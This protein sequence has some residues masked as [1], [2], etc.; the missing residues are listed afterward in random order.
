[1]SHPVRTVPGMTQIAHLRSP[2]PAGSVTLPVEPPHRVVIEDLVVDDAVVAELLATQPAADRPAV[3]ARALVVGAR[4]LLTMG[5]GVNLD[6]VDGRVRRALDQVAAEALACSREA[7]ESGRRA[8][9][10][11][12]DPAQRSSMIGRALDEFSQARD[13]LLDGLNPHLVDSHTGRFIASLT[14]LVGPQGRLDQT[15]RDALDPDTDG[16]ALARLAEAM[17]ARF[18]ELRDL[19][20]REQGRQAESARG[21]AKGVD[22]EDVVE[23]RL[24]DLAGAYGGMIVE[25]TSRQSGALGADCLVGDFVVTLPTGVRVA[26]EAKNVARLGLAGKGGMLTELDRAMANREADFGLCVSAQDAFPREVGSFAVYGGRILA[27][28]DGEGVMVGV[29]LRWAM[30]AAAA[31]SGGGAGVDAAAL[32]E[33]LE[34]IRGLAQR[35][36]GTKRALGDV[37]RTIDGVRSTIDELRADLLDDVDAA[38]RLLTSSES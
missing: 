9:A 5:L 8:F 10:E 36:S 1:M 28:D 21:T 15:L 27:V 23:D 22:F 6:E 3:A 34:R 37:Q 11:E 33:R 31:Q 7:V 16:S 25:R 29:A 18:G 14:D 19:I 30:A 20:A 38:G 17:D 32:A 35:F 13:N 12:F 2:D 26:V 24:R 4:G